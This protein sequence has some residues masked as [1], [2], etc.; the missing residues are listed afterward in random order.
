[1][2]VQV[3]LIPRVNKMIDFADSLRQNL[4]VGEKAMIALF[5]KRVP[6]TPS[7]RGKRSA[8]PLQS[9]TPV[10]PNVNIHFE[11]GWTDSWSHRRCFHE[12]QTL[13]EA[14]RCAMPYGA[15]WYVIAVENGTPRQLRNAEE[16]I[17][18]HFRFGGL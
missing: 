1:M 4:A 10:N 6:G 2:R 17:V 12:H 13:I 11:A 8:R 16:E 14:A 15:G 3:Q 9:S 7:S 5:K 18:N